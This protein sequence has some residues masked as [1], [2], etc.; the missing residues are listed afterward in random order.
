MAGGLLK[1]RKRMIIP[2]TAYRAGSGMARE[3]GAREY[4]SGK[5]G[6]RDAERKGHNGAGGTGR[7]GSADG[8]GPGAGML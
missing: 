1:D 3:E 4:V 6:S 5:Q 2:G 7:E 8:R